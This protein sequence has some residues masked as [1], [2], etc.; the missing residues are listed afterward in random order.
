VPD[1]AALMQAVVDAPTEDA[2]RAAY[3]RAVAATDPERA[4]LIDIQ[5]ELARADRAHTGPPP[6]LSNRQVVLL[7]THGA[8]W[9]ADVQPLVDKWQFLRGFPEVVTLDAA[10]F[11]TVAPELYR[12]APVLHLD[13]TGVKPVA[14][15]LFQSP[16]LDRIRSLSL[17]HNGIGDAELAAL[18]A[19][20]HLGNLAWLQLSNNKI[21][22]AGLEA[23]AASRNLPRLGYVGFATN[24]IPDPTPHHADEYDATSPVAEEL[25]RKYGP[26]PWLDARPRWQWP[27]ARDAVD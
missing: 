15:E 18:A 20:P 23:L 3:A 26:R 17:L 14:T 4:E 5:L 11:L 7:R 19:S 25:Q 16:H 2:P 12:R 22:A 1:L 6:G 21:G 27:P 8:R 9:A 13:L 24:A 10:R